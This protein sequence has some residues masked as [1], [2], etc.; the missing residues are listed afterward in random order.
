MV[1]E[2]GPGMST[3]VGESGELASG[4]SAIVGKSE[5]GTG[6]VEPGISISVG[7]SDGGAVPGEELSPLDGVRSAAP[8][9]PA[10]EGLPSGRPRE[11]SSMVNSGKDLGPRPGMNA[12]KGNP[13]LPHTN[14]RRGTSGGKSP[15]VDQY[16][17]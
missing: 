12:P 17:T 15:R 1:G 16:I 6:V 9:S 4:I 2:S 13:G 8:P 11:D 3:M 14:P 10:S 7:E 5:E